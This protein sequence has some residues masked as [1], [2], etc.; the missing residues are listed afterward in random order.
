MRKFKNALYLFVAVLAASFALALTSCGDDKNAEE[1][2]E[3]NVDA[4]TL[5]K[6]WEQTNYGIMPSPFETDEVGAAIE[7]TK[8]GKIKHYSKTSDGKWHNGGE[9]DFTIVSITEN[10]SSI[11]GTYTYKGM[12]D[13]EYEFWVTKEKLKVHPKGAPFDYEYKATSGIKVE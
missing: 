11:E 8:K 9:L 2:D 4:L 13:Q 5:Y 7:F 10:E 1:P 3:P 6:Q 12:D